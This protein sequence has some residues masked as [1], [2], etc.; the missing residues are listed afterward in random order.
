MHWSTPRCLAAGVAALALA[1]CQQPSGNPPA[2]SGLTAPD[3]SASAPVISAPPAAT[4]TVALP[5]DHATTAQYKIAIN[6]PRLQAAAKPLA[7]ALRATADDAKREFLQGLPDPGADAGA[8]ASQLTL[9]LDFTTAA[10]T[11]A[12]TSVRETGDVDTGGAHPAPVEGTFVYDRKARR[13]VTLD[14]LFAQPDA[15]RQAL[16]AFARGVL[17]RRLLSDMQKPGGASASEVRNWYTNMQQMLDYGTKPSKVNFSLF[18]VRAGASV[19]APS[20]G[21]TLVFPPYQ[22]APYAAGTQ[23]VDVPASVFARFLTPGYRGAFA[24]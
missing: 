16:A 19:D 6:M 12:F 5:G 17:A 10:E 22:V 2:A 7:D 15:A 24:P 3:A 21:L 23:T 9:Q 14:D 8:P 4:G 20:P 11:A 13:M 18:V 1:A